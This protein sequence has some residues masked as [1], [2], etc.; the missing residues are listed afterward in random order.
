VIDYYKISPVTGE[1]S[2]E[3]KNIIPTVF[4]TFPG[5]SMETSGGGIDFNAWYWSRY[6][7]NWGTYDPEN[8][9][10]HQLYI[11]SSGIQYANIKKYVG[12]S[13]RCVKD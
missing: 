8:A 1:L 5:G 6:K 9:Q 4:S 12:A 3:G 2:A 7:P 10:M 11:N 13:I